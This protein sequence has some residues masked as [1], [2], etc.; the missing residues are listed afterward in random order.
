[1]RRKPR[2]GGEAEEVTDAA[3]L[4]EV[5]RETPGKGWRMGGRGGGKW[6]WGRDCC[7]ARTGYFSTKPWQKEDIEAV[8]C[9][10]FRKKCLCRRCVL[11]KYRRYIHLLIFFLFFSILTFHD[12][13][14]PFFLF[15]SPKTRS[16]TLP[17]THGQHFK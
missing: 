14:F 1:M 5:T 4:G 11:L 17:S 12:F 6:G 7:V 3:E 16:A 2:W 10:C 15:C 13:F 9:V 8:W